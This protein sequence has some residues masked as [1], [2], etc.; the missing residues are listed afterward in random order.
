[1]LLVVC[2][3]SLRLCALHVLQVL[4]IIRAAFW[5]VDEQFYDLIHSHPRTKPWKLLRSNYT[6]SLRSLLFYI[7]RD[8]WLPIQQIWALR[9]SISDVLKRWQHKFISLCWSQDSLHIYRACQK[10]LSFHYSTK[11]KRTLIKWSQINLNENGLVKYFEVHISKNWWGWKY[12]FHSENPSSI[13]LCR[14]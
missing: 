3:N 1:M 12:R 14:V 7:S 6:S 8:D 5:F 10:P 13:L 2:Y 11:W 9:K 4:R